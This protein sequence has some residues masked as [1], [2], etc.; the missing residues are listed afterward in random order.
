MRDVHQVVNLRALADDGGPEGAAINGGVRADFHVVVN[1]DVADLKH[2]AMAALVEHIAVAVRADDRAGVDGNA[3]PD[4][5]FGINHH[6]R[7][8]ADIVAQL[9]VAADM[10]AAQERGARADFYARADHAVRS[11]MRG[12]I[13]LRRGGDGCAGMDPRRIGVRRKKERQEFRHGRAGVRHTDEHFRGGSEFARHENRRGQTLLGGGEVGFLFGEREVAGLGAVGGS[14]A[15]QYDRAVAKDFALEFFRDL[16]GCE[17]HR[18]RKVA[19]A[20]GK[21]LAAMP[22]FG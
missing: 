15:G 4:L 5:A 17:C 10:I 9:A 6:V 8:Q 1:D 3:M 13:N 2:L 14:E 18:V 7:K 19:A 12:G 20:G 11:D 16:G 21:P 22:G